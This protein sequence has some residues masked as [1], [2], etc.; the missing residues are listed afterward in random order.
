[1]NS[2]KKPVQQQVTQPSVV[3]MPESEICPRFRQQYVA[4]DKNTGKFLCNSAIFEGNYTN[5]VFLPS[6]VKNL[7]NDVH[8]AYK[9]R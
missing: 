3:K 6:L 7:Q 1:M 8:E 2:E 4:K 5:L 9:Q